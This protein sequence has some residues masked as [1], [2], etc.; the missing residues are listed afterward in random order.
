MITSTLER[1]SKTKVQ[2][3][4]QRKHTVDGLWLS[5]LPAPTRR[6]GPTV[7]LR[8]KMAEPEQVRGR[9]GTGPSA[10]PRAHESLTNGW[11]L[12]VQHLSSV[13]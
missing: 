7:K 10:R 1:C 11:L 6:C 12:V 13:R 2:S 5:P 8:N 4:R 9:T 3:K